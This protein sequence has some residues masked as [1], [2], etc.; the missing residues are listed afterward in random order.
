MLL[1]DL[2]TCRQ[3]EVPIRRLERWPTCHTASGSSQ[4][5]RQNVKHVDWATTREHSLQQL[6]GYLLHYSR[7]S[8]PSPNSIHQLVFLGGQPKL[9]TLLTSTISTPIEQMTCNDVMW[10]GPGTD[11][12]NPEQMT[13]TTTVKRTGL[14]DLNPQTA[15]SAATAAVSGVLS[16]WRVLVYPITNRM[17]IC[18][19]CVYMCVVNRL[20][21]VRLLLL[22]NTV[23]YY[24]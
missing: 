5:Q 1:P 14:Y 3:E 23:I 16:L 12:E 21:L 24:Q 15:A 8:F 10:K 7:S 4:K 17:C 13:T 22:F 2:E 6:Q 20:L 11:K 9:Q 19:C 18:V